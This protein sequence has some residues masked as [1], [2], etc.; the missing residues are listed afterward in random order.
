MFF[1]RGVLVGDE[2]SDV[3]GHAL[4]PAQSLEGVGGKAHLE[5][6]AFELV[7]HAVVVTVDFDV[8][9]D[10]DGGDLPLGV[11]VSFVRQR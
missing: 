9:V 4:A 6:F 10:I 3:A 7:G 1:E 11:L 8:V 5:F 2:A